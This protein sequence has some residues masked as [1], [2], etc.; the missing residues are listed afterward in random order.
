MMDILYV[1]SEMGHHLFTLDLSYNA[2]VDIP[3]DALRHLAA[4]EWLNLQG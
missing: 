2:L 1:F 4:L 3:K